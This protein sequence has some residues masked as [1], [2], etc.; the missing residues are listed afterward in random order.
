MI[1]IGWDSDLSRKIVRGSKRNDSEGHIVPV[2]AIYDFVDRSVAA[3]CRNDIYPTTG[4][5]RR[6]SRGFPGLERCE[7]FDKMALFADPV[8]KVSNVWAVCTCAMNDQHDML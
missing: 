1:G 2:E 4:C 5:V 7:R 8:H 6:K 3:G